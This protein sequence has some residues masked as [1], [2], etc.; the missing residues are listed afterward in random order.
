M[1]AESNEK[2][3]P[4]WGKREATSEATH[5]RKSDGEDADYS[6]R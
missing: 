6:F 2:Y 1:K 4:A 3:P 5:A